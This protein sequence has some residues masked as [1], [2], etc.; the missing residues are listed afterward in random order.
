[1][2][3]P[4]EHKEQTRERI[5]KAASR[6][7]RSRGSEGA[8]I[9]DLMRDLHLTHG[10]FYRH[11][12]SKEELFVAA[13]QQA[14][15]DAAAQAEKAAAQAAPGRELEAIMDAYLDIE[16]CD[17]VEGGCPVAALAAEIPRHSR[18]TRERMLHA[19]REHVGR[20]QQY[21][22]GADEDERRRNASALLSSM[23]GAL[24]IARAFATVDERRRILDGAKAFYRRAL[25][26]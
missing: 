25:T 10:G 11:F 1:M 2:R 14:L 12:S 22:P 13:F 6:R 4:A 16:H 24:T 20:M 18:K 26:R 15:D 17:D 5:L 23:A 9:G 21:V 3:Y 19:L 8:V 7:F